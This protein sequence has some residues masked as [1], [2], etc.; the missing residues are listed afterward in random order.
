[1][2]L[3]DDH[4]LGAIDD[5]RPLRSHERDLAH[6]DFLLLDAFLFLKLEGD[7]ERRAEGLAFAHGFANAQLR[8]ADLVTGE[9]Q[10][11]F[12]IIASDGEYF[13]EHRLK[14][15]LFALGGR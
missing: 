11:D 10:R 14:A 2:E 1:M 7:V 4:A 15:G 3:R 9:I 6:I 13:L 5:K 8:L 12:L